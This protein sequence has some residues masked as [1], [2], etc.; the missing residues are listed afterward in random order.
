MDLL[1]KFWARVAFSWTT[2]E[3]LVSFAKTS[4]NE[5]KMNYGT[6]LLL[7]FSRFFSFVMA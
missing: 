6:E 3:K 5:Q 7:M 2:L 4:G 1:R